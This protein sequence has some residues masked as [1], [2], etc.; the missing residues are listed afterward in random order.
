M[1]LKVRKSR[2]WK[3]YNLIFP[4]ADINT[5]YIAFGRTIFIPKHGITQ[6]LMIHEMTHLYQQKH[7]YF[8]A[9]I[10]WFKYVIDKKFRYS[11]ELQAYSKQL[12]FAYQSFKHKDRNIAF[13]QRM[14][15]K[16]SVAKTMS[17]P[18]YKGMVSY[19]QARK[20]IEGVI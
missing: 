20:D 17:H 8:Y 6:D 4:N 16:D 18:M 2:L 3:L 11:Q 9:W 5:V 19:E 1:K 14:Q 10:W 7:S 15:M 12:K 13:K